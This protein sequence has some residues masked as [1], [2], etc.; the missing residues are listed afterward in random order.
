MFVQFARKNAIK[1]RKGGLRLGKRRDNYNVN[2]N[3]NNNNNKNNMS[4]YRNYNNFNNNNFRK[5]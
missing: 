1:F 2:N 5:N 3:N 4:N